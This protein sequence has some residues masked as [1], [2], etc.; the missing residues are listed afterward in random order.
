MQYI[1]YAREVEKLTLLVGGE[2]ANEKGFF[3]KPTIYVNVSDDSKL[4]REEI[5]GPVLVSLKPWKTLDEVIKRANDTKYGLAAYIVTNNFG[6]VEKFTRQV[7]AGS[8]YVNSGATTPAN[9][10]FGGCKES[11][12]G[13]DNGEEGLL[14]YTCVKSVY[15]N[16]PKPQ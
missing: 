9:M 14:E 10:P 12:F 8:F 13:R 5:F 4:A 1:T 2:R 6:T 16:F 3:V 15:M 7:K 11:G